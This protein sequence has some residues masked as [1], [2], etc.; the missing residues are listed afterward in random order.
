MSKIAQT[1]QAG[2]L[3]V[4][5]KPPM[6]Q[7]FTLVA[8]PFEL[9]IEEVGLLADD[10][11]GFIGIMSHEGR[12]FEISTN[13]I[14]ENQDLHGELYEGQ[15]YAHSTEPIID[16]ILHYVS[17]GIYNYDYEDFDLK[18][19]PNG[20]LVYDQSR[21]KIREHLFQIYKKIKNQNSGSTFNRPRFT[22]YSSQLRIG[23]PVLPI[24]IEERNYEIKNPDIGRTFTGGGGCDNMLTILPIPEEY[25][26]LDAMAMFSRHPCSSSIRC[27]ISK[28]NYY[29][30]TKDSCIWPTDGPFIPFLN[31]KYC[32]VVLEGWQ[33]INP[34]INILIN[35]IRNNMKCSYY[36]EF[37]NTEYLNVMS[38]RVLKRD[39]CW[40]FVPKL[41]MRLDNEE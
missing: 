18:E 38:T 20:W 27:V 39:R 13:K 2:S 3:N 34:E 21:T 35:Y 26:A 1:L 32:Y 8:N 28:Q 33:K 4:E 10:Y 40:L 7:K 5:A 9:P 12:F 25:D 24:I 23:K 41:L 14:L 29:Y 11:E 37:I 30:K 17:M 6:S 36:S 19:S 31:N 15:K 16:K 22:D